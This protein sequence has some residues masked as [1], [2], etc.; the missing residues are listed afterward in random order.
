MTQRRLVRTLV[1]ASAIVLGL[2]APSARAQSVSMVL[3]A[4]GAAA[5]AWKALEAGHLR[6]AEDRFARAREASPD[7]TAALVGSAVV[8]RRLGHAPDAQRWLMRALQIDPALSAASLL[9][10][11]LARES[12]DLEAALRIYEAALVR[13]PDHLQLTAGADACRAELARLTRWAGDRDTHARIFFDGPADEATA[14]LALACVE[15][16][17]LQIG[18]ALQVMP[19]EV[20][21]VVLAT[22]AAVGR[23][24]TVAPEWSTS[25]F[26]GRIRLQIR[27][28]VKDQSEFVRMITHEYAHAV[29]RGV[30]PD[31]VPAW[32]NEGLAT[33]LEP[34][35]GRRAGSDLKKAGLLV[36][37][38]R[39]Q[40]SFASLP[41]ALV[42]AAYAQS[43][44]GVAVLIQR[45]GLPA[46]LALMR[47]LAAGETLD[48]ALR[49]RT[50]LSLEG[51]QKEFLAS[52]R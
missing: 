23:A 48:G 3:P 29:L 15:Q 33:L 20:V 14:R 4:S 35:G 6:E 8:A 27:P 31:G 52:L 37:W 32:I 40:E 17:R 42:T 11:A 49:S 51:F 30:A 25:Q 46:V 21:T 5:D 1:A 39:L 10:A 36:P 45:A 13:A 44:V 2:A 34:D 41:P 18:T 50:G 24:G 19:P 28:P 16:A 47:D 9:L 7:E 38:P 43:A 22:A 26:D 12:G